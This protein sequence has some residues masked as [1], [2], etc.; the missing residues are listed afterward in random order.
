MGFF[1]STKHT[2]HAEAAEAAEAEHA[3]TV[4]AVTRMNFPTE[5]GTA[6]A[7]DDSARSPGWAST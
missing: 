5:P 7:G 2:V 1:R 6:S 4:H 3:A